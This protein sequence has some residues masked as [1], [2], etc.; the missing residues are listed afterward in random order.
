MRQAPPGA[1]PER[2]FSG[3]SRRQQHRRGSVKWPIDCRPATVAKH[4]VC[5]L[6]LGRRSA[7][8]PRG[9]SSSTGCLCT[10]PA[11]GRLLVV[12]KHGSTDACGS[13]GDPTLHMCQ[14]MRWSMHV[15]TYKWTCGGWMD[16]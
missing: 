12:R 3:C 6:P 4:T 16:G 8:A 5:G 15:H 2:R 13:F 1:S 10:Q 11:R 7:E 9:A 14:P